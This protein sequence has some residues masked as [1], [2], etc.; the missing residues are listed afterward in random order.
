MWNKT[1]LYCLGTASTWMNGGETVS[2]V[3]LKTLQD[4]KMHED[5]EKVIEKIIYEHIKTS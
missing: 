5:T 2:N 3:S 4:C 1:S